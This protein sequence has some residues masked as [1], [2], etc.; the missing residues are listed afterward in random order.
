MAGLS[1]TG[2]WVLAAAVIAT[3]P[4]AAW[5]GGCSS[6][7][8]S[9]QPDAS[10][11]AGS[12]GAGGGAGTATAGTSGAAGDGG[13]SGSGGIGGGGA[14][15]SGADAG[16]CPQCCSAQA[17]STGTPGAAGAPAVGTSNTPYCSADGQE[18]R[19]C[20][21]FLYASLPAGCAAGCIQ[22]TYTFVWLAQSCPNGC[23]PRMPDGG[24]PGCL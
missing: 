19:Y 22:G 13:G 18:Y 16:C 15:C 5:G 2:R 24:N 8:S 20:S 7:L 3:A 1:R 21:M 14:G 9:V 17:G 4:L 12:T 10:G 11:Q 23:G 6:S